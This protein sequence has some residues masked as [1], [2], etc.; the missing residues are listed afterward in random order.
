MAAESQVELSGHVPSILRLTVGDVFDMALF[1]WAG[2]VLVSQLVALQAARPE[3]VLEMAAL[4]LNGLMALGGFM[5][6]LRRRY[7]IL[8]ASFFFDFCFLTLAPVQQLRLKFDPIFS[9]DHTLWVTIWLCLI[10]SGLALAALRLRG[11]PLTPRAKRS[12]SLYRSIHR[13]FHPTLL[14]LTVGC[15][16]GGLFALL[17]SSVLATR[18]AASESVSMIADKTTSLLFSSFLSPLAF[19]GAVIGLVATWKARKWPWFLVFLPLFGLAELINNPAVSARFRAA[20]L[21]GFAT[22]AFAGW[23]RTR[24]LALFLLLGLLASPIL[25]AFRFEN[26]LM[27]DT[28]TFDNFFSQLDFDAFAM[29]SHSIRYVARNG[30]SY[31]S[32]LLSALLFFVPRALWPEKSEHIG[33]Y[34]WPEVRYYRNVWTDNL[35]SPPIAE[36][37]FAFGVVGATLLT[38]FIFFVFVKLERLAAAAPRDFGIQFVVCVIPTMSIIL[39]RGSLVVGF[40]EICGFVAAVLTALA[41]ARIRFRILPIARAP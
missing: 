8:L 20:A 14:A 29:T 38:A 31:G 39:L 6:S 5:V 9:D 18:E 11:R 27:Q 4:G 30:Y 32:N 13:D 1:G 24:V 34:V 28:R 41:I 16:A 36:G 12:S 19:S 35:S 17:G 7:P 26:S 21:L 23:N 25:N 10:F 3:L 2:A 22:L 40:S 37:Y 15:V 33:Y